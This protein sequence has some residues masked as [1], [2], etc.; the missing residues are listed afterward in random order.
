MNEHYNVT[1]LDMQPIDPPTGGGRIRLLGLYHNLGGSLS[2]TYVG[3]YDWDGEKY[4]DHYVSQSLREI[5]V[6]LSKEHFKEVKDLQNKVNGK[7]IIDV[8]FHKIANLSED[9]VKAAK[10]WVQK[11]DIVIFSHPWVYPLVKGML[12]KDKQLIVYD[13]HNV[14]GYL[15]YNLLG[16]GKT[17]TDIVREVVKIEYELCHFAD[18]VL[19]CSHEDRELFGKLYNLPFYKMKVI[20]NGYIRCREISDLLFLC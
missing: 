4:R 16:G 12:N 1:V 19:T 13:S 15:R 10:E 20:P 11:S 8:T 17:E 9:Y 18:I 6:P 3:T 5:N 14:E 7:T 2:T